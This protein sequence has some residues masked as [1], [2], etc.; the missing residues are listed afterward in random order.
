MGDGAN[1]EIMRAARGGT[2][3][4]LF[5]PTLCVFVD[6]LQPPEAL[7]A[8]Q[9]W[10]FRWSDHLKKGRDAVLKHRCHVAREASAPRPYYLL[11]RVEIHFVAE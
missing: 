7:E 11:T 4:Q 10:F 9:R 8:S 6:V 2:L 3:M 1:V 5:P